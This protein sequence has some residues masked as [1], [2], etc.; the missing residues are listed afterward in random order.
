MD[1][2]LIMG[3]IKK[4]DDTTI[5]NRFDILLARFRGESKILFMILNIS[6]IQFNGG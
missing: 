6:E 3:I 1:M 4:L 5:I 2:E